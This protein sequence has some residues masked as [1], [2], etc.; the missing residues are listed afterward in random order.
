M[1]GSAGRE[2]ELVDIGV[3]EGVVLDCLREA[4]RYYIERRF[5]NRR[6]GI[7]CIL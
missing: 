3:A 1:P 7:M 4:H 6:R 2:V 5:C